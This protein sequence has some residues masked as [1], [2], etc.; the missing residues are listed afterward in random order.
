MRMAATNIRAALSGQRQMKAQRSWW[1]ILKRTASEWLDDDAMTWAAAVACYT[2]L[3]LASM[4]VIAIK[5]ATVMLRG[6][7]RA[8][9]RVQS[10]VEVW[11]GSEAA[12]AIAPI[13]DR[14]IHQSNGRFAAIVSTVLVILGVGGLFSELQQAMNR[15][16]K[17]KPRPGTA[18]MTF[19]RARV[20]SVIVMTLAAIILVANV[21]VTSWLQSATVAMG[22]RW[23]YLTIAIDAVG[24]IGVLT[25]LFALLYRTI[26]D[27]E[28]EWRSTAIGAII[29]AVLFEIGKFGLACYFKMAAPSSAFGAAGSLAA[30]LIWVYYSA[31]IVFFGA[32]FTQ[33]YA[34]TRGSGVRPSKHAQF[35]SIC[36]ETETTTPNNEPPERKPPRIS[37]DSPADYATVLSRGQGTMESS[38]TKTSLENS[39][40]VLVRNLLAAGAGLAVGAT[41]GGLGV[42]RA[43]RAGGLDAT[44]LDERLKQIE[45]KLGSMSRFKR[46]IAEQTMN[47]RIDKVAQKV[48]EAALHAK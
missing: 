31:Q 15:I 14:I 32:E 33:V 41:I 38:A 16:W 21:L 13:I 20:K 47:E 3:A 6:Q 27:A 36:D 30:V 43:T 40:R 17:L 24:S 34:K 11:M 19:V 7:D 29:S 46:R 18:V 28:I 37:F 8:V 23:H 26:P 44:V 12:R 25:L 22:L 48:R 5:V 10:Q 9:E 39:E 35:L 2:L 1:N 45:R 4:L 42:A